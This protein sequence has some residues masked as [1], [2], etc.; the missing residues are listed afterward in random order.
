ML[1]DNVYLAEHTK[2]ITRACAF[3]ATAHGMTTRKG[4]KEAYI[5]HPSRVAERAAH[6]GMD[7]YSIAAAYLHDV[8]EDT[9]VAIEDLL[10]FPPRVVHLVD[11]LTEPKGVEEAKKTEAFQQYLRRL[12]ADP[13]AASLKTIDRTDNINDMIR[14]AHVSPDLNRWSRRYLGKTLRDFPTIV[15]ITVQNKDIV[16][17]FH[18]T[19]AKL[20]QIL[21]E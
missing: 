14:S 13:D 18:E 9:D 6:F 15:L 10:D 8:V 2:L 1:Y 4:I 12:V 19:V 3:A 20:G 16:N 17:E 11:L 5:C 21:G 7:V